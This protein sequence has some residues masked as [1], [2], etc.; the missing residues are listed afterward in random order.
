MFSYEL[1]CRQCGWRTVCGRDDAIARL[2]IVGR[3]R[4]EREPDE[5]LVEVLL[6]E[7][8]PTMTCPVCK[9][10]SLV[11]RPSQDVDEVAGDWQT[12]VLCEICREPIALERLEAIPGTKRCAVCAA[13]AESGQLAEIEPD[14][15]P[16]CGAL[17]EVRVSQGSG[18]TRYKRVCTGEPPCRL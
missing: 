12:A 10:K 4:R 9:D 17:V 5:A 18:I 14:Y 6:V 8:A 11:A 13:K 3:L 2:R 16:H 15:C 1:T 7:A